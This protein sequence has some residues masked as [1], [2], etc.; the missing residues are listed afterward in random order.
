VSPPAEASKAVRSV[1]AFVWVYMS[2]FIMSMAFGVGH[3]LDLLTGVFGEPQRDLLGPPTTGFLFTASLVN[4][5]WLAFAALITLGGAALLA[6]PGLAAT[7]KAGPRMALAL[8]LGFA[9]HSVG[10]RAITLEVGIRNFRHWGESG[11]ATISWWDYMA[12]LQ[13]SPG[14][15]VFCTGASVVLALYLAA[16]WAHST[17]VAAVGS[18]LAVAATVNLMNL[19]LG[20]WP[21]A[22]GLVGAAAVLIGYVGTRS[23]ARSG[24][25]F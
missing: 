1:S 11:P 17:K 16:G 24:P 23:K 7:S 3:L 20:P 8:G 18:M 19:W 10:V 22:V 12:L 21:A 15:F 2:G 14:D 4:L 25:A 9:T 13:I 6:S 5:G